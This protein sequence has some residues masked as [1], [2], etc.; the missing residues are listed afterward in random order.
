[1]SAHISLTDRERI[2][3]R[4]ESMESWWFC[5]CGVGGRLFEAIYFSSKGMRNTELK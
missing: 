2:K 5:A 1:M 4:G 3:G